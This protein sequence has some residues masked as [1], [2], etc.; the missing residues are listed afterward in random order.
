MLRFANRKV[1]VTA[2]TLELLEGQY[3]YD[4]GTHK[5]KVDPVLQL[6]KIQTFLIGPQYFADNTIRSH[7]LFEEST[8]KTASGGI[9]RKTITNRVRPKWVVLI[10]Y[11]LP[12]LI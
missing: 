4:E 7:E 11:A 1:H 10:R 9:R 8:Y 3:L 6:N 5:A 12:G 2:Q